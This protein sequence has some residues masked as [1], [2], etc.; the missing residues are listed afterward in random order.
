MPRPPSRQRI[1]VLDVT[2]ILWKRSVQAATKYGVAVA[3]VSRA[4]AIASCGSDTG[5]QHPGDGG[6]VGDHRRNQTF[7][8]V[9]WRIGDWAVMGNGLACRIVRG[10]AP[11]S[12]Y[13]DQSMCNGAS[14][15]MTGR[16]DDGNKRSARSKQWSPE[17]PDTMLSGESLEVTG[18]GRLGDEDGGDGSIGMD[19]HGLHDR[20]VLDALKDA[21]PEIRLV[22][23]A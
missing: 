17:M 15:E 9:E 8:E 12:R 6:L 4:A 13:G 7:L 21:P 2:I 3:K 18:K 22:G 1:S 23:V 19:V 20:T 16:C 14:G 11:K 5:C 10:I